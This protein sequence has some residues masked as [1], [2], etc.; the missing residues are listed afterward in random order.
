[1]QNTSPTSISNKCLYRS[2]Y[3]RFCHP[4]SV[5]RNSEG[6][7]KKDSGRCGCQL[8]H[9]R[10]RISNGQRLFIRKHRIRN[11]PTTFNQLTT[12]AGGARILATGCGR[13]SVYKAKSVTR[14]FLSN[15]NTMELAIDQL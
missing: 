12:E 6:Y 3:S 15:E 1:M 13:F 7:T 5:I 2:H 11:T 4:A 10:G 8:P 9:R 14:L